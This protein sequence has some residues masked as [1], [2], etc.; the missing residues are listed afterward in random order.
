VTDIPA[1][2][3]KQLRDE[4]GAGMMDCKRALAETGGDLEAARRLLRERGQ[5]Q[6]AK[7]AGRG[8]NEGKVGYRVTDDHATMVAVASETEPVSNNDQFLAFA[9]SV[10]EAVDEQGPEAVSELEQRRV[11][12]VAKLGE[13]VVVRGAARLERNGGE[14]LAGYAHPPANKIGVLVKLRGGSEELARRLAMHIAAAAPAWT[15]RDDVPA[16]KVESERELLLRSDE[17]RGKPEQARD[18]IVEGMLNKRFF[19]AYPGGVLLE[20]PWIHEPSQT[21]GKALEAEDA[22]VVEFVRYSVAE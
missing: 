21:V 5:A 20:Q 9:K 13:N 22:D 16:E 12:L 18:K 15:R 4:T 3:V 17:L 11:D 1:S 7:R 2:L 19:A 14:T 6:A 8:T 10:L